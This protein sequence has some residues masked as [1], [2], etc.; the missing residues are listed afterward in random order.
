[1]SYITYIV[2]IIITIDKIEITPMITIVSNPIFADFTAAFVLLG[3]L[4]FCIRNITKPQTGAK[5]QRALIKND[6]ASVFDLRFSKSSRTF[7]R[8]LTRG[9]KFIIILFEI[10]LLYNNLPIN[11]PTAEGNTPEYISKI[12]RSGL[13]EFQLCPVIRTKLPTKREYN[14]PK[15]E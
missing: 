2:L 3:Y 7:A 13:I 8:T 4:S 14:S 12:E 10:L 6:E 9:S 15:A 11:K 5:K 1:M